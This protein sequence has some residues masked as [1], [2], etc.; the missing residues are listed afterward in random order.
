VFW[1]GKK[2]QTGES[3]FCKQ[4]KQHEDKALVP[5][6][7]NVETIVDLYEEFSWSDGSQKMSSIGSEFTVGRNCK[8]YRRLF[9][10]V[11]F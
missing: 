1:E 8:R 11:L 5:I 2:D 10:R 3:C 6:I 7:V 9:W 4:C